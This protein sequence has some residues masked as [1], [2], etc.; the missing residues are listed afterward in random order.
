MRPYAFGR[1]GLVDADGLECEQIRRRDNCCRRTSLRRLSICSTRSLG[2]SRP[3]PSAETKLIRSFLQRPARGRRHLCGPVLA[4]SRSRIRS[5]PSRANLC[6]LPRV[7]QATAL[8]LA[9]SR[10]VPAPV[11]L[12]Q[13][14]PTRLQHR[15]RVSRPAPSLDPARRTREDCHARPYGHRRGCSDGKELGGLRG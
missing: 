8:T 6:V 12:A 3:P 2:A 5:R 4:S 13:A 1:D 9:R 11:R 10:T 7:F 14:R 15:P